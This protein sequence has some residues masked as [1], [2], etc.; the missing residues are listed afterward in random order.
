M[1]KDKKIKKKEEIRALDD[2]V[3]KYRLP[4]EIC[5]N[6]SQHTTNADGIPGEVM[7]LH[8]AIFLC[9]R[10][11][12]MNM[13][14]SAEDHMDWTFADAK[15]FYEEHKFAETHTFSSLIQEGTKKSIANW[16][17]KGRSQNYIDF[18]SYRWNN[19]LVF[20]DYNSR[21]R[22]CIEKRK[23]ADLSSI[24]DLIDAFVEKENQVSMLNGEMDKIRAGVKDPQL[25][26]I[27]NGIDI[28]VV[29]LMKNEGKD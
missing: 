13:G 24:K 29:D 15:L 19:N 25:L 28:S 26:Q 2:V 12:S 4:R 23:G 21:G 16:Y 17:F 1:S 10:I 5:P 8:D 7:F 22:K 20:D 11:A 6:T 18:L 27:L 3:D 9:R 14:Y